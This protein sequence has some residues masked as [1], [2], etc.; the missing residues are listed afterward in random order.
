MSDDRSRTNP[1]PHAAAPRVGVGR[2]IAGLAARASEPDAKWATAITLAVMLAVLALGSRPLASDVRLDLRQG[3]AVGGLSQLTL[4]GFSIVR[5]FGRVLPDQPGRRDLSIISNRPYPE[6]FELVIEGWTL[7]PGQPVA[8][9]VT[10]GDAR[11]RA[12]FGGDPSTKRVALEN[13]GRGRVLNLALGHDDKL[14]V[15]TIAIEVPGEAGR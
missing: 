2:W 6:R 11:G 15:R 7:R 3:D 14:A 12:R 5:P 8:L 13:P 4:V 10:L 9:E 1:Q